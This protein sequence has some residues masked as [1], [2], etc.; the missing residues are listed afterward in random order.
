MKPREAENSS[1]R[2]AAIHLSRASPR[3]ALPPPHASTSS[4]ARTVA[5]PFLRDPKALQPPHLPG[6]SPTA[7]RSSAPPCST[8]RFARPLDSSRAAPPARSLRAPPPRPGAGSRGPREQHPALAAA[9]AAASAESEP[10]PLLLLDVRQSTSLP[11]S[12]S[13]RSRKPPSAPPVLRCHLRRKHA[14]GELCSSSNSLHM[15]NQSQIPPISSSFNS[16]HIPLSAF[17]VD[18]WQVCSFLLSMRS[19]LRLEDEQ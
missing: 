9:S 15:V 8:S 14:H 19:L 18:L 7:R 4:P 3:S 1:L 13:K 5:E 12:Q 16:L 10:H 17:N 2:L 11:Q 6:L